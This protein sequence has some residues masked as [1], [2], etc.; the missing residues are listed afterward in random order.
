[1]IISSYLDYSDISV[2][3]CSDYLPHKSQKDH[4]K[5][6]KH[7]YS[8]AQ[9]PLMVSISLTVKVKELTLSYR[10]IYNLLNLCNFTFYYSLVHSIPAKLA[11]LM[12]LGRVKR[13]RLG[14]FAVFSSWK[15]FPPDICLVL[16]FTSFKFFVQRSLYLTRLS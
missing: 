7:I 11:S 12:F 15:V 2:G 1:M 10:D 8:S 9:N 3:L 14:A 13:T 5:K 16:P 6:K 4:V